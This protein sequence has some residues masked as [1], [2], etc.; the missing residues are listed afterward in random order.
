MNVLFIEPA[1]RQCMEWMNQSIRMHKTYEKTFQLPDMD[2]F[3]SVFLLLHCTGFSFE[4]AILTL[5]MIGDS[6]LT[7]RDVRFVCSNIL[8]YS[9]IGRG[10]CGLEAW[11]SPRDETQQ[12]SDFER[13]AFVVLRKVFFETAHIFA[14]LDEDLFGTRVKN[15]QVKSLSNSQADRKGHTADVIAD[16]LFR[17]VIGLRCRRRCEMLETSVELMAMVTEGR[18]E[19]SFNN[20][21]LTFDRGYGKESLTNK[22][23]NMGS[24]SM[25]VL[26]D[27]LLRWHPFVAKSYF[28]I[29][30]EDEVILF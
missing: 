19:Q 7:L 14:N 6:G 18:G 10:N 4:K 1:L 27:H 5:N 17:V 26:P 28:K 12:R 15:N 3:V 25:A 2:R 23:S 11:I 9:P 8:G 21:T 30:Q 16:V 24:S 29:G 20:F 22:V 13:I